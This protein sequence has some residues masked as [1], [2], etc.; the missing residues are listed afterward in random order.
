MG[1]VDEGMEVLARGET[2]A[3]RPYLERFYFESGKHRV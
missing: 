3:L 1:G 2:V